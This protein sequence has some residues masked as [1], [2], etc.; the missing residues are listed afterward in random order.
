MS[1]TSGSDYGLIASGIER[2]F[3]HRKNFLVIGLTGRTG[4]GCTTAAKIL[5]TESFASLAL[6]TVQN[7][8]LSHEDRKLRIVSLWAQTHWRPFVT[9]SVTA[10]ILALALRDGLSNLIGVIKNVDPDAKISEIEALLAAGEGDVRDAF[11]VAENVHGPRRKDVAQAAE[12]VTHR[13]SAALDGLKPLLSKRSA[14]TE[15][16]QRLGNNVRRSGSPTAEHID[17]DKIFTIPATLSLVIGVIRADFERK[18]DAQRYIVIDALRH[19]YEIRYL[20]ERI[21]SFYT[22][23]VSTTDR[24]RERRLHAL[25]LT[26]AQVK[27]ISDI[28][29]PNKIGKA[30]DYQQL[31]KQNIQACLE[32]AD[33]YI[34]N[35]N[36]DSGPHVEL[37]RQLVRYVALMQHPGLVT[38]TAVERCMQAAITARANSGC[39]SRQVG[40][41]VTDEHFSVKAMGWNDVPQGQVPCLLRNVGHLMQGNYDRAA[42][43]DYERTNQEF[44]AKVVETYDWRAGVDQFKGRNLSYCFKTAYNTISDDGNQVHTRSLHAEENAFLQIAKY[45]GQSIAGGYLFTTASPCELCAKKAYQLGI[46]KIFYIDPY[47]GIAISHVLG[48]GTMKPDLQLFEGAIGSAYHDLYQPVMPY[49]DELPR[50]IDAAKDKAPGV[51]DR[52]RLA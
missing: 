3:E 9:V 51:S 49:K 50:L 18:G 17:P 22:V 30:T 35:V 5:A 20:R 37:T 45:G 16:F 32:L 52:R 48:S 28:E 42:Y 4:S 26:D 10:V 29:Y 12:T 15:L 38:P 21:S 27:R 39:I 7:P 8:P 13:M 47:P 41:V 2:V 36:S 40:A 25:Q 11:D 23:A 46:R 14:Y 24:E 34:S 31:V 33:I 43:S 19:P 44:R 1:D 6:P